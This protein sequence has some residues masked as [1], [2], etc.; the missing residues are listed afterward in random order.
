VSDFCP[1]GYLPTWTAIL[2]AAKCWFPDEI[3]AFETAAPPDPPAKAHNDFD[4]AVRAFSQPLFPDQV[5]GAF[6]QTM[7]R[8]RSFLHQGT[9][10]A[11]YFSH[12][13]CHSVPEKFWATAQADGALESSTYWPFGKPKRWYEP[14]PLRYPLFMKQLELDALLSEPP[15]EKR[16]FPSTKTDD[17]VAA[18]RGLG[19]LRTRK[20]QREAL[21]NLPEFQRYHLTD[22]VLRAAEKRVPRKPGR[23]RF[24]PEE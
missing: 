1:D 7:Y 19:H 6:E 23:K 8:L 24:A 15:A 22:D 10:K 5:R 11:Y 18:L 16:S 20:E 21:R 9:L 14:P 13:G 17:L 12:D 3:P 2:K 4:A